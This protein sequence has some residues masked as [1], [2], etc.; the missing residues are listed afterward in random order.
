ML[1]LS[2]LEGDAVSVPDIDLAIRVLKISGGRIRLG[3][4]APEHVRILRSEKLLS[5]NQV[6]PPSIISPQCDELHERISRAVLALQIAEQHLQRGDCELAEAALNQ[7]RAACSSAVN[8]EHSAVGESS[9]NYF[10]RETDVGVLRVLLVEHP[11]CDASSLDELLSAGEI[12]VQIARGMDEALARSND[13]NLDLVV[14]EHVS[15]IDSWT[16]IVCQIRRAGRFDQV[17]ICVVSNRQP[18]GEPSELTTA[19]LA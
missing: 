5:G 13:A 1:V 11:E 2:R 14:F 17:P 7:A 6:Q 10:L 15:G 18:Q 3:I 19:M 8:A 16:D 4:E 9:S 12:E